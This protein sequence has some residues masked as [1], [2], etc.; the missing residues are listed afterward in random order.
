MRSFHHLS[1]SLFGF[2]CDFLLFSPPFFHSSKI[3]YLPQILSEELGKMSITLGEE[4]EEVEEEE[5]ERRLQA[6]SLKA[7]PLLESSG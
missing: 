7:Y 2:S 5:E 4:Q 6:K 3:L 1:L